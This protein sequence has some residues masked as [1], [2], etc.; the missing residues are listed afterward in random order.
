MTMKTEQEQIKE[1][2]RTMCAYYTDDDKCALR[3]DVPCDNVNSQE[4]SYKEDAEI[5]YNAGYRK[6]LLDTENSKGVDVVQYAPRQLIEGYTEREVEKARKETDEK[7]ILK[8]ALRWYIDMYG[9][10]PERSTYDDYVEYSCNGYVTDKETAIAL[11]KAKQELS[12]FE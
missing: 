6:V 7:E 5:L 3:K 8:T 9:C 1:M 12:W 11:Q 4:C 2:A 10:R